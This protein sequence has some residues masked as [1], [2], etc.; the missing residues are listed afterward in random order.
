MAVSRAMKWFG[1]VALVL[2]LSLIPSQC[3]DWKDERA[4]E[5]QATLATLDS[6]AV[7]VGEARIARMVA[8]QERDSIRTVNFR[9]QQQYRRAV[10]VVPAEAPPPVAGCEACQAHNAVVQNALDAAGRYI[11]TLERR[12]AADSVVVLTL[13]KELLDTE[14]QL[15]VARA[16]LARAAIPIPALRTPGWRKLLPTVQ[17]GYGATAALNDGRLEVRHGPGIN[18]GW[19]VSF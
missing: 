17:L 8:E 15:A 10:A 6:M 3:I 5:A 13:K 12:L 11:V 9:L 16:Q 19:R 18:V 2:L 7:E 4:A 1:G 14:E